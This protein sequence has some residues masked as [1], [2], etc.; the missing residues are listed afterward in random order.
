MD[1]AST[2]RV[3][4]AIYAARIAGNKPA[5]QAFLAPNAA[6]EM[7]GAQAFANPEMVGPTDA[8]SAAERLVNDF[9]FHTLETLDAVI[10]EHK[11]AVFNRIEVSY[12]GG[13]PVVSEV[14]DLWEF[15]ADGKVTSLR[16]FV[17]TDLIRRLIGVR[18]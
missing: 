16:Q 4:D 10:E 11:A 17:D 14:C 2:R 13:A 9:R 1:K 15:D 7:V 5:L 6:Y 18:P 8:A 12:R 3:I